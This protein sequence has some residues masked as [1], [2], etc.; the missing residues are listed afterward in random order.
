MP[1]IDGGCA[2]SASAEGR[3]EDIAFNRAND[4]CMR[5]KAAF[6]LAEGV[7]ELL[8]QASAP[9]ENV[10]QSAARTNPWRPRR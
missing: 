3:A 2:G 6:W 5:A 8:V 9:A 1:T 7:P 4:I 10:A